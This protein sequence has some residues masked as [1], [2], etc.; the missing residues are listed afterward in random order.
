M[1]VDYKPRFIEAEVVQL[2]ANEAAHAARCS[3]ATDDVAGCYGALLASVSELNGCGEVV[4]RDARE[5]GSERN[6]DTGKQSNMLAEDSF[7]GGLRED[8]GRDVAKRIGWLDDMDSPDELAVDTKVFRRG[9]RCG[10]G[11]DFLG[12]SE[13]L[14][15]AEDL[16]ID[17]DGARDLP[18]R[19]A[20]ID[21]ERSKA[22]L[23]EP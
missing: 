9:E 23:T 12:N 19:L 18:D 20:L 1:H 8:H 7:D 11:Q 21:N 14:Q 10:V 5:F 15:D 3:V 2:Y 13:I 16:V 22:R 6:G 17:G 4:L